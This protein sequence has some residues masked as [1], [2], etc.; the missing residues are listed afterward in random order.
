MP[1]RILEPDRIREGVE[2]S[3]RKNGVE[4]RPHLVADLL[5]CFIDG[6]AHL[7]AQREVDEV[8]RRLSRPT[9]RKPKHKG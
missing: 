3:L 2:Y 8:Q 1:K 9:L 7:I 6:M 5:M 4:P